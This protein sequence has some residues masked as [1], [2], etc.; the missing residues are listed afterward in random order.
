ML[1][2]YRA[3]LIP[4][5]E[6]VIEGWRRLCRQE[7]IGEIC[8]ASVETF[9]LALADHDRRS[10]GFD[11]AVEFPPHNMPA[12]TRPPDMVDPDLSGDLHDYRMMMANAVSRSLPGYTRFR[13]AFPRWDNTAKRQKQAAIFLNSS[14]AAYRAWLESTIDDT[15]MQNF[16]DERF[17]FINAWGE[18]A[19]GAFLEPDR[20]F[21][22]DY[23]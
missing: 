10:L 17:V 11:P 15:R 20:I 23:L 1:L 9:D 22:H 19:E 14:P 4:D 7:G 18:W 12:P 16:R 2:L 8:L 13:T 5:L 6:H 3:P 21:M